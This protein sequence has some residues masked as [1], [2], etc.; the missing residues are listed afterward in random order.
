MRI[1]GLDFGSHR[2]GI[3]ISDPTGSMAQPLS[4][5]EKRPDDSE[6]KRILEL[7]D[8][9]N[10]DEV[11]VGLPVSMSGEIGA[12]AQVVLEYVE[13]LKNELRVPVITWDERLTTSFAERALM[14]SN[15][16]RSRRKEIVDK[17]AAAVILQ[18]YLDLK[19]SKER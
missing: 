4:V 16:K 8:E 2:I 5:I 12:Q 6:I 19:R 3:A 7:V 17:V 13:K 11:V 14:E 10:V 9:Y 18:G 1:L 15:V